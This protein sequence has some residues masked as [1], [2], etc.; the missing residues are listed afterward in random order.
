MKSFN[1]KLAGYLILIVALISLFVYII[2]FNHWNYAVM[3][4]VG[5][6]IVITISVAIYLASI[7][8][9]LILSIISQPLSPSV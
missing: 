9:S 1:L 2:L 4:F 3:V 5:L 6:L 8:D 7:E